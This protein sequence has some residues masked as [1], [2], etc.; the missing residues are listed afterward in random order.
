MDGQN[1]AWLEQN[2]RFRVGSGKCFF[3]LHCGEVLDDSISVFH[4]IACEIRSFPQSVTL[5]T[6]SHAHQ[7]RGG[8]S[9]RHWI[10]SG[11]QHLAK[12][13]DRGRIRLIASEDADRIEWP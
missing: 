13:R 9:F 11:T 3:D 4:F 10:F 1:I 6:S 2:V 7:L 12:D 8:H 5:K